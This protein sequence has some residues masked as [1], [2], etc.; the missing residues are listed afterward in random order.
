M[1]QLFRVAG[2]FLV[3][4]FAASAQD[5]PGLTWESSTLKMETSG[6]EKRRT[7]FHFRNNSQ[8]PVRILSVRTSC[9]CTVGRPQ[10]EVYAPG[11][12][13]ALPVTHFSKGAAGLR[14][15]RISVK[16]EQGEYTLQLV[17]AST[18]H[19]QADKRLLTW[20]HAEARTPKLI[21]LRLKPESFQITAATAD[22]DSVEVQVL[23][24]EKPDEK[25]LRVTPRGT[26]QPG[27]VR[28]RL[29]TE[30]YVKTSME[31]EFFAVLR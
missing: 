26:S 3:L 13:G 17:V 31:T 18:E 6:W 24:G 19:I 16:T 25:L 15:Y 29:Q 12:A 20:E 4:L 1:R 5:Q 27:R 11:E 8:Q 2:F 30:P 10:K 21:S 14:S 28:I 7:E 23:D 22:Q 9:G